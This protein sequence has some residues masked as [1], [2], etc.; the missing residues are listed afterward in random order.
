MIINC[1]PGSL[2]PGLIVGK[3]KVELLDGPTFYCVAYQSGKMHADSKKDDPA[4]E[5]NYISYFLNC[6]LNSKLK[7]CVL[8]TK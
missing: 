2:A 4:A 5:T 6:L 3:D 8:R 7:S 1:A